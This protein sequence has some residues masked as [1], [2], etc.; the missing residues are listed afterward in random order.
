MDKK[1]FLADIEP[2]PAG[3]SGTIKII[4]PHVIF[5]PGTAIFAYECDETETIFGQELH[6]HYH[7]VDT[8]LFRNGKWQVAASQTMR[9]YEDPAVGKTDTSHLDVVRD[10]TDLYHT[11]E[12][13][14]KDEVVAGIRRLVLPSGARRPHP[15]PPQRI[16]QGGCDLRPTQQR[17]CRLE[18]AGVTMRKKLFGA[19]VFATLAAASWVKAQSPVP[20]TLQN[21]S[22]SLT[23]PWAFHIGDDPAWSSPGFDDRSWESVDLSAAAGSHDADVGLSG[24]VKG[25]GARGHHGV[26]GYGWYRIHLQVNTPAGQELEIEG[27]PAVDSAYQIFW[28]GR[29]LGGVGSFFNSSSPRVFS[30]QP[31]VF[32]V[33]AR[34]TDVLA[35]RVWM[36]PWDLADS[37]GGGMRIAPILGLKPAIQEVNRSEWI[38]TLR[39]YIVEVVEAIGFACAC[40]CT[41]LLAGFESSRRRFY[42]LYVALLF[43]G[44][45]RLNQALFFWGQFESVPAFELVSLGLLYPLALAAWTAAWT[46]LAGL[47]LRAWWRA[48]AVIS[49]LYFASTL[50]QHG[51]LYRTNHP[52]WV[53]FTHV[54]VTACRWSLFAATCWL[55]VRLARSKHHFRWLLVAMLLLVSV[56]QFAP[57]LSQI[58]LPGIWFPF[59]TGVSRA[60]FAYAFFFAVA[61]LFFCLRLIQLARKVRGSRRIEVPEHA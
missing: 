35:I 30:I 31:R 36:G 40:L 34:D 6:A 46:H 9:Y 12:W 41:W 16:R 17:R 56:G 13:R 10:G 19:C 49:V 44:A 55:A 48:L 24:Y 51:V 60:Q 42:W 33:S 57:E 47:E 20:I 2:M 58:G 4:H 39:G 21:A 22:Q 50:I 38:E 18:K 15:F 23:G 14:R 52:T 8:W 28:N 59:G 45:Y 7:S 61:A 11:A 27:P 37:Q 25:W 5:A 53:S 32:A 1:V 29:L 54:V 3:Y 43:T 26:S